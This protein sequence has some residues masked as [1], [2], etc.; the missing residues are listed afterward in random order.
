MKEYEI[1]DIFGNVTIVHCTDLTIS[2]GAYTFSHD[3]IFQP[4][5]VFSIPI[6]RVNTVKL[7]KIGTVAFSATS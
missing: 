1:E 7:L 2:D 3:H 4:R 5:I 6:D